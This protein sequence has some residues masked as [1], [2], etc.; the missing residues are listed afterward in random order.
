MNVL[1]RH[2]E[3]AIALRAEESAADELALV[4]LGEAA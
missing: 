1:I 4:Q 3:D 2:K